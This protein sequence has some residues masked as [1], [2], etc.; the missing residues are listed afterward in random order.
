MDRAKLYTELEDELNFIDALH[1]DEDLSPSEVVSVSALEKQKAQLESQRVK[2]EAQLE[3]L[4]E[5][6]ARI[7]AQI[8]RMQAS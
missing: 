6:A 5:K 7:E 8:A 2:I 4:E 3:A 1:S